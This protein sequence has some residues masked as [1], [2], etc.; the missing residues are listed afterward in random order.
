MNCLVFFLMALILDQGNDDQVKKPAEVE[1]VVIKNTTTRPKSLHMS[2][3]FAEIDL[4][5]GMN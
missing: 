2:G 3:E 1:E 4:A 5:T